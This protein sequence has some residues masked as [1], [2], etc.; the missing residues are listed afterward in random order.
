MCGES[1]LGGIYTTDGELMGVMDG[2]V[3]ARMIAWIGHGRVGIRRMGLELGV[4]GGIGCGGGANVS[5]T[6]DVGS[7]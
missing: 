5:I 7:H 6:G 3:L 1:T 2:R 4:L